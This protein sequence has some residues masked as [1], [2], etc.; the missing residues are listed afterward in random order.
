MAEKSA[1]R[2]LGHGRIVRY[3]GMWNLPTPEIS[4]T[5]RRLNEAVEVLQW[6]SLSPLG[7]IKF[8]SQGGFCDPSSAED[9]G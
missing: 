2:N 1:N 5:L 8:G 7:R 9:A 6:W 4:K 3:T